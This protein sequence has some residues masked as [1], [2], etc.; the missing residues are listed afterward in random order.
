LR[1][2]LVFGLQQLL[3]DKAVKVPSLSFEISPV[4]Q[5]GLISKRLSFRDVFAA[6]SGRILFVIVFIGLVEDLGGAGEHKMSA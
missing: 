1:F 3:V 2:G 4:G 5:A 6:V